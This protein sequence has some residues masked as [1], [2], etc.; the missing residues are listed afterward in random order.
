M[1]IKA[2]FYPSSS[3]QTPCMPPLAL[4][5]LNIMRSPLFFNRLDAFP[6]TAQLLL[7]QAHAVVAA[8]DR[9]H[10]TGHA[11]AASPHNDLELE[12]LA[13]PVARVG[14]VGACRTCPDADG[15]ILRSG[16]DVRFAKRRRRPRDVADPVGVAGESA[17][18]VVRVGSRIVRPQLD[19]VVRATRDEPAERRLRCSR[20]GGA[21]ELAGGEGG[22]PGDGVDAH[23]VGGEDGVLEG[24]VL[25]AEHADAA[26]GAGGGQVAAGLGRRPGDQVDR[27]GVQGELVDAL[28]LVLRLL[29]PDQDAAVVGGGCED[30]AVF[31]VGP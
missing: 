22:A 21:R 27:G 2:F 7:P 28:P 9:Q 26:V 24:V 15:V 1:I 18:V 20:E 17:D 19:Q 10:I 14:L 23:A 30:G 31:G 8:T 29:A 25:E 11:P 6:A 13:L 16:R 5:P 4:C 3:S 12:R